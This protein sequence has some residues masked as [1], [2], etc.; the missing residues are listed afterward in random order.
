M[1]EKRK[2]KRFKSKLLVVTIHHDEKDKIVV[3][4]EIYSED[5]GAGGIR[6]AFPK[7][8]P[9]GKIVDLKLF[10]FSDPISLPAKGKVIWC[11]QKQG[12]KVE[13]DKKNSSDAGSVYW[14]GV[15]F[16]NV[17]PFT[18][19]RLLRWIKKDFNVKEI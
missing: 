12:L 9:K 13:Y 18:R 8:L 7:K 5:I 19:N 6:I 15:Q 3:N 16:V 4:D 1:A 14:V 17:D 2:H 10:L 11:A